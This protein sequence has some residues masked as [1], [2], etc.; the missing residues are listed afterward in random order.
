MTHQNLVSELQPQNRRVAEPAYASLYI[1]AHVRCPAILVECGF[2][3]NEADLENLKEDRYQ[4]KLAA[5]LL[6]SYLQFV[7]E[8]AKQ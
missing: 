1:T 6:Q 5:V 8:E 3:S 7:G 2:L 4:T